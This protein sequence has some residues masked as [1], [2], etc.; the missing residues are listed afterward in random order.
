MDTAQIIL[1]T[2]IIILTFVLVAL[3]YKLYNILAQLETSLTKINK[4]TGDLEEVSQAI[5]APVNSFSEFLMGFKNGVAVF[6]GLVPQLKKI[7]TKKT[8]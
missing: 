2:C 5:K 8:K 6:N 1:S 4:I 7:L 3:G